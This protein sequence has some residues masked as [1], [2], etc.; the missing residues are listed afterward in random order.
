MK[1]NLELSGVLSPLN[2]QDLIKTKNGKAVLS[3]YILSDG[4]YKIPFKI[5]GSL[6]KDLYAQ[7][8][9]NLKVTVTGVKMS[10]FNGQLQL[11]LQRNGKIKIH[12]KKQKSLDVEINKVISNVKKD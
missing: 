8:Y 5:W 1:S 10:R 9:D 2:G 7:R 12:T 3:H 11:V 6:P 4:N